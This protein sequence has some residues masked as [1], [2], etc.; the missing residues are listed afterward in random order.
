D[1]AR[2]PDRPRARP[3]RCP[4]AGWRLRHPAAA[5]RADRCHV[6]PHDPP[7]DEARE[8]TSRD[9]G[10]AVQRRRG[11]HQRRHC[12]DGVGYR[13]EL[14]DRGSGRQRAASRAEGRDRERAAQGHLEVRL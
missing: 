1:P 5:D 11:D 3:G 7:A 8:G 13:R 10:A 14:R 12:R 2:L 4:A 6:F 9:A